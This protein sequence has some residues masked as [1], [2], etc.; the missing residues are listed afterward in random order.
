MAT[1][2]AVRTVRPS[3][4]YSNSTV[5]LVRIAVTVVAA[6]VT[7]ALASTPVEYLLTASGFHYVSIDQVLLLTAVTAFL[8]S[9]GRAALGS[10]SAG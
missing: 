8:W 6:I 3:D 4:G 5:L 9:A 2:G 7:V 10:Y 1:D